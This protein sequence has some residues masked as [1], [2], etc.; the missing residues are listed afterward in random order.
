M[1]QPS[2]RDMPMKMDVNLAENL[3]PPDYS[4]LRVGM[5][6]VRKRHKLHHLTIRDFGRIL[7]ISPDPIT[8]DAYLTL[9]YPDQRVGRDKHASAFRAHTRQDS[10]ILRKIKPTSAPNDHTV[11]YQSFRTHHISP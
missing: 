6:V 10:D 3:K 9:L 11:S 7:Q 4:H 2:K 8:E 5:Y 1:G